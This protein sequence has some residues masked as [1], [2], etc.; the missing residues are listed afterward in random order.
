MLIAPEEYKH[1]QQK[2][3]G[4][5]REIC[6][7]MCQHQAALEENDED[8]IDK[9]EAEIRESALSVVVRSAWHAPG[10]EIVEP[11]EYQILLTTGGPALRIVGDLN[12][13]KEPA[14]A[15]FEMQD[16]GVPWREVPDLTD[17]DHEILLDFASQFYFGE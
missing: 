12:R 11:V 5:M 2:A 7:M 8:E 1:A 16:W 9:I 14:N 10:S 6:R 4:W 17:E 15:R 13:Y 3:K